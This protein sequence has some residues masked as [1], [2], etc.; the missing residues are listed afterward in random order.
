MVPLQ[1]LLP[2]AKP[3]RADA[4]APLGISFEVDAKPFRRVIHLGSEIECMKTC[5]HT[6]PLIGAVVAAPQAAQSV[7]TGSPAI[8]AAVIPPTAPP[9]PRRSSVGLDRA[10]VIVSQFETTD[11]SDDEEEYPESEVVGT[12]E[13]EY[14]ETMSETVVLE[15]APSSARPRPN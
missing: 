10:Q 12:S 14:F 6:H 15:S 4:A 5:L 7:G 11:P 13:V 8:T 9:R 2:E 3:W 1:L